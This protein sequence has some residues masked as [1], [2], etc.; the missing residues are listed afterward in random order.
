MF[1]VYCV[2]INIT[3]RLHLLLLLSGVG[4]VA[5]T[6]IRLPPSPSL[7]LKQQQRFFLFGAKFRPKRREKY[8]FK[9]NIL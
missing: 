8:N 9:G 5:R 2:Y 4:P 3:T 6:S 7:L 1:E